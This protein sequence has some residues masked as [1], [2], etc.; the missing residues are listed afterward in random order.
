MQRDADGNFSAGTITATLIGNASTAQ[1]LSTTRQ[2]QLTTDV[3]A[4]GTF[5]GSTNLNLVNYTRLSSLPH[6]N[7]GDASITATYTKVTVD[8]KGRI[9]NATN[10]TTI[11]DYNLD[12]TVEGQSA[13]PYDL[14]L[15]AVAGLNTTGFISRASAGNMVT[16]TVLG[17][18]TTIQINNGS[19]VA[20]DPT[21]NLI[22]T[23]VVVRKL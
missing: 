18:A 21:I 20:G 16:R 17:T 8:Q 4:S 6:Y 23:A 1:R 10:P 2:I 13:Q 22:P 7:A 5:D 11:Q 9:I 19:G 12:G 15:V 14:D 3:S